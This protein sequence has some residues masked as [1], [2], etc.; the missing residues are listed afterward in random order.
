[1]D[2]FR[3]CQ[4]IT[5]CVCVLVFERRLGQLCCSWGVFF[6]RFSC[7]DLVF[8]VLIACVRACVRVCLSVC[9][10]VCVCVCVRVRVRARARACV[11]VCFVHLCR[12][13]LP[14]ALQ[15]ER[16]IRQ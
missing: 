1:M 15:E 16:R 2:Q 3:L 8:A 14:W 13:L 9:V 7:S 4:V 6:H 11:C 12:P 10:C 5:S